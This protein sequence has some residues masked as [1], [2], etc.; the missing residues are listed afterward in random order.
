MKHD[1]PTTP[2]AQ[3]VA[4]AYA[5]GQ[6]D[7]GLLPL[8][9]TDGAGPVGTMG[10]GDEVIF[11]NLRGE[12]EIELCLALADPGFDH[13]PRPDDWNVRLTTMIEYHP[14]LPAE[15]A[16]PSETVDDG[17]C[18]VISRAGLKQL[19]VSETEK[20]PHVTFFL[21]GKRHQPFPGEDRRLIPS[22]KV[23]DF[24]AVPGMNA[25]QVAEATIEALQARKHDFIFVNLCNID[26][27]GHLENEGAVIEAVQIV[28]AQ[29][30]RIVAA[31]EAAGWTIVLSAD[32]GSAEHWRYEDGRPDTGHTAN[33]VPFAVLGPGL[34]G[35]SLRAGGGLADV[36]P[37]VLTM[38]GLEPP[39]IYTGRNLISGAAPGR[40]RVL[41]LLVDGLGLAEASP[42]N[43]IRAAA[44]PHLDDLLE[45]AA[46]TRLAAAGEAV[47]L[48][49]GSVGNSEVGHQHTG[50]GR[51]ILSDRVRINR[52]VET[53][54]FFDNPAFNAAVD[55]CLAAGKRLH[56]L[57]IVSFYSSHGSLDHLYAL[58][59]LCAGRGVDNFFVHAMLGRRGER[60]ESG[61]AYIGQ[62]EQ[63]LAELGRGRL[64]SVIGRYWSLDRE[65]NWDR[66]AKAFRLYARG[67]G[68]QV[69]SQ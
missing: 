35:I 16:F 12:R 23:A 47:G 45:R 60:H 30:G 38:L 52:A 18:Q 39:A 8:I 21:N 55:R 3:G 7:E 17:L 68:E 43:L 1:R 57:G 22:P 44:T 46:W 41:Y 9:L 65:A 42:G 32:H 58:M 36:A 24:A 20:A 48:P 27:I 19:K 31:A 67:E 14:D 25:D 34:D 69:R 37:T 50:A 61:A 15:V 49:A 59:E 6:D 54:E 28:D 2:L 4:R 64:A 63:K 66:V 62:V 26:V 40:R 13:F 29:V 51:I 56:L 53:G 5:Q 10:P 33:D 11:C